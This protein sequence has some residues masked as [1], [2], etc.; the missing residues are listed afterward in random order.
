MFREQL[1]SRIRLLEAVQFSLL[2]VGL[3][4]ALLCL[5]GALVV[6]MRSRRKLP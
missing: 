5:V 1:F 3:A 4:A 2:G 6:R